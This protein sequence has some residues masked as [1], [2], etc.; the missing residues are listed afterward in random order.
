[1]DNLEDII[2]RKRPYASYFDFGNDQAGTEV[3]VVMDWLTARFGDPKRY[4]SKL[5]HR[6]NPDDPPDVVLTDHEGQLHGIEVTE[7]VDGPTIKTHIKNESFGFREYSNGEFNRL[8]AER[9]TKKS[10]TP[11][12]PPA[13][14]SKRL[15]I[16]SAEPIIADGEGVQFLSNIPTVNQTAFDEVWFMIPPEV[17]ISNAGSGNPNCRI[18]E[19]KKADSHL[20]T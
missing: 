18:Y 19:I 2:N 14:I 11:F 17:E 12:K 4:F 10:Q 9:I 15:L 16:Y 7:F 1:M 20:E 5:E 3:G 6:T 8:V 13:C